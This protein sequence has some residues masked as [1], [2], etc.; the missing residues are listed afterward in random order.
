MTDLD[1]M[2]DNTFADTD[3]SD[4]IDDGSGDADDAARSP[5]DG[6]SA[7]STDPKDARIA[8]LMSRAQKAEAALAKA[9]KGKG[10]A[11]DGQTNDQADGDRSSDRVSEMEQYWASK[12]REDIFRREGLDKYFDSPDVVEGNSL[13]EIKAS[14]E[15]LKK[16]ADKAMST[17]RQEAFARAGID[18]DIGGG[19]PGK[20]TDWAALSDEEF[21]KQFDKAL[22]G[23]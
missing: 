14:A 1:D 21:D 13:A 8:A 9:T 5:D 7:D 20:P 18:P 16:V 19:A 4:S 2:D 15:R 3:D 23:L 22:N 12:T 17:A 6:G 11:V 10:S